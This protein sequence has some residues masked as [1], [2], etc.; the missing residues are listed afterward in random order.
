MGQPVLGCLKSAA[1]PPLAPAQQEALA[2]EHSWADFATRAWARTGRAYRA[3]R[4][5]HKFGSTSW[6]G[7][8]APENFREKTLL[9][10][11]TPPCWGPKHKNSNPQ[12]APCRQYTNRQQ[13]FWPPPKVYISP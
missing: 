12:A 1:V 13:V 3:P 6:R 10:F 8:F 2:P 4:R 11:S 5:C 7:A 9:G